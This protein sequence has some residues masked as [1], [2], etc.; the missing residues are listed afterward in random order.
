MVKDTCDNWILLYKLRAVGLNL[1]TFLA[2]VGYV[3]GTF[4]RCDL[5]GIIRILAYIL[6]IN[7]TVYIFVKEIFKIIDR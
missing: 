4:T 7:G 2:R 6:T 1:E 5:S 3:L